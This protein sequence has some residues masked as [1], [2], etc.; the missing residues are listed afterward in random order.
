MSQIRPKRACLVCHRL[1]CK[2]KKNLDLSDI[3]VCQPF[4]IQK[5]DS[6]IKISAPLIQNKTDSRG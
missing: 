1:I 6:P 2:Q 3:I 5:I 4:R